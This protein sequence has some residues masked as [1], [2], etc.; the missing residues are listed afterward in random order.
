MQLLL[1]LGLVLSGQALRGDE[2][3]AIKLDDETANLVSS[4][5]K[6]SAERAAANAPI[7]IDRNSQLFKN[8][9]QQRHCSGP[10]LP[11]NGARYSKEN[12]HCCD[13]LK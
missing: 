11:K 6:N 10:K 9:Q 3:I 4:L 12:M 5:L 8:Y 7:I 2:E 13:T 1:L